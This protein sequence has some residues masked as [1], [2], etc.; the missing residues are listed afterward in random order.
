M[1]DPWS[2]EYK[3]QLG[4]TEDGNIADVLAWILYGE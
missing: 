1:D 2:D 4:V 3:E